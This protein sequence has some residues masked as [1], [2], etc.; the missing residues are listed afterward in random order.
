[1]TE[2]NVDVIAELIERDLSLSYKLLKLINSPAFLPRKKIH[3]IKQAIVLLGLTE[4]QKWVYVLSVRDSLIGKSDMSDEVIRTSLTRGKMCESIEQLRRKSSA[5][6][7]YFM[8]GMFSLMDSIMNTQMDKLLKDL[9]LNNDICTAL[10]GNEN[11]Y[12]QVLDLVIAIEQGEWSTITEKC[13]V[14]QID[15]SELFTI[16]RESLNWSNGIIVSEKD[17]LN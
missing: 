14:F 2:P 16:Y 11:Q 4:L 8:T 3:S 7:G 12:K 1:M 17:N 6:S 13:K 10:M 5:A 9:P 15:E